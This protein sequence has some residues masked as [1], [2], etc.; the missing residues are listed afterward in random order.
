MERNVVNV[1][2]AQLVKMPE[3]NMVKYLVAVAFLLCL[4]AANLLIQNVGTV[5]LTNGPCLIPTGFGFM[6]PSGVLMIGAALLLR[7]VVHEIWGRSTAIVLILLGG[8]VSV[9]FVGSHLLVA[10]LLAFFVSE[11]ADFFVYDRFRK[12]NKGNAVLASGVVGAALDTALFSYVAF[13]TLAWQPGLLLGKIYATL[14][15]A[16][17]LYARQAYNRRIGA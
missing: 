9:P 14:F 15:V 16:A 7:D 12:Q 4:P 10:S 1:S 6:A 2:P 8:L 5:C 3:R 11:M 13:G 17:Y